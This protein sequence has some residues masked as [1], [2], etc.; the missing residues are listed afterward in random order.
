M[1]FEFLSVN[2]QVAKKLKEKGFDTPCI[3]RFYKKKY[4]MNFLGNLYN[5][6]SG[7]IDKDFISAPLFMQVRQWLVDEYGFEYQLDFN[8]NYIGDTKKHWQEMNAM[9]IITLNSVIYKK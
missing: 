3:A 6:N 2:E 7:T 5:H 9:I 4:K 1:T 8:M